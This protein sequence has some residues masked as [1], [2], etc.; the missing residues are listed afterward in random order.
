MQRTSANTPILSPG[1][2]KE[3]PPADT[4]PCF[5]SLSCRAADLNKHP[6]QMLRTV[7]VGPTLSNLRRDD[8]WRGYFRLIGR[9]TR[10][11]YLENQYF[12]EPKLAEAIV[13]QAE[14]QPE[15]IVI[16]MAGTGTDDRQAVDKTATGPKL[17]GQRIEVG[18]TQNGFALRLEFFKRLCVPRSPPT[19]SRST[20]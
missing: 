18:F 5:S 13:K 15:L 12:H 10:F 2:P 8:I 19:A 6:V 16:V 4:R 9:A 11:I 20:R 7:S 17:I 14:S 3:N 1:R